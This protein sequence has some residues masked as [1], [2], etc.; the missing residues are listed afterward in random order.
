MVNILR[1]HLLGHQRTDVFI[2]GHD[3][4][5]LSRPPYLLRNY[6]FCFV[7]ALQTPPLLFSLLHPST[8]LG[9]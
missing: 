1:M 8:V 4:T 5:E 9:L 7:N 2:A 6:Y 3:L